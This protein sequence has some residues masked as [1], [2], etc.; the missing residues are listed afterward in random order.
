[1][2]LE[3]KVARGARAKE[4]LSD[5]VY[6]ETFETVKQGLIDLW[7]NSPARDS[8]GREKAYLMLG[9]LNKLQLVLQTTMETGM[10]AAA[11]LKHQ[12]TM[13][14]RAKDLLNGEY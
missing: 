9:M 13:L 6:T 5:E 2:E 10:L 14:E 3:Q 4:I 1:M 8:E 11:D 7:A 12:R